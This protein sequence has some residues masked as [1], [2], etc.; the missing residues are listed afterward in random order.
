[1][2][3]KALNNSLYPKVKKLSREESLK[4]EITSMREIAQSMGNK[5]KSE[6][7]VDV[8]AK[9]RCTRSSSHSMEREEVTREDEEEQMIKIAIKES[10][11]SLK[12]EQEMRHKEEIHLIPEIVDDWDSPI[13]ATATTPNIDLASDQ[14]NSSITGGFNL[15][16][17][18]SESEGE[19]GIEAPIEP[20]KNSCSIKWNIDK[21]D[22]GP[23]LVQS[24]CIL[25]PMFPPPRPGDLSACPVK[26]PKPFYSNPHDVQPPQNIGGTSL[27]VPSSMVYE[28]SGF[29]PPLLDNYESNGRFTLEHWRTVMS[30]MTMDQTQ[31]SLPPPCHPER[32]NM[33]YSIQDYQRDVKTRSKYWPKGSCIITPAMPPP[34]RSSVLTK[35]FTSKDA[36]INDVSGM[37]NPNS[38][39][40][41][42]GFQFAS[43]NS[44]K[45]PAENLEVQFITVMSVELHVRTRGGLRPDPE[46][47]PVLIVFYYVHNDWSS[48]GNTLGIIAIDLS[49]NIPSTPTKK[50]NAS[51][52]KKFQSSPAK[53]LL[54]KQSKKRLTDD[55]IEN[56]LTLIGS[57][58]ND[59][60]YLDHCGVSD[61]IHITYV[62][63]EKELFD[64]LIK[65]VRGCDPDILLGYEVQ[66][67]SWGYLKARASYLGINLIGQLSRVPNMK[68]RVAPSGGHHMTS[69]SDFNVTGRI[70]LSVWRSMKDEVSLLDY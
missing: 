29:N 60:P 42:F 10:L 24:K 56:I 39:E 32:P 7:P 5:R 47:D 57:D 23:V 4:Y 52:S 3:D 2:T 49:L 13:K 16:M 64:E 45:D 30:V 69:S 53:I 54:G 25:R 19:D 36:L 59:R 44:I 28:L 70:M 27:H 40:D 46:W 61:D 62:A 34:S 63:D 67:L 33:S 68:T 17:S 38:C 11:K 41:S 15:V 21:E 48:D 18:A 20:D 26:H 6:V 35:S 8:E 31:V 9:R 12:D 55:D 37:E 58:D 51:P 50:P 65:L 43:D 66:M 22:H 14:E 1:L